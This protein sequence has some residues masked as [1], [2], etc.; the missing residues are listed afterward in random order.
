MAERLGIIHPGGGDHLY[1][2]SSRNTQQAA[3]RRAQMEPVEL[4][5]SG[6]VL[7]MDDEELIRE[8]AIYILGFLGYEV[9]SCANGRDAI[10]RFRAAR[11]NNI[12]FS[13]VILDLTIP[14]GM[15]GR[16]RRPDTGDRS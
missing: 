2:P 4:K 16:R 1:G 11:E 3:G 6:K 9:D 7:V 10:E 5:G 14:G 12:P 8:I 15:G 13:Y